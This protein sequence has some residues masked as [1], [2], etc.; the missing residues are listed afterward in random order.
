VRRDPYTTPDF[1]AAALITIATQ[2]DVLDGGPLE[3]AGTS[4]ALDPMRELVTAFREASRPIVHVVRLYEPDGTNVDLCR[5]QSIEDGARVL[6]SGT[7]GSQLA[8]QLLPAPDL[9][10][11]HELLLAGN[12]QTLGPQGA[13]IYKPRWGCLLRHT[14]GG[15]SARSGRNDAGLLRLQLSQLPAHLDL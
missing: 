3:I 4:A 6:A 9:T 7:P 1:S 8:P 15:P 5:R 14:A 2:R 13:A 10:L 12:V 11:D